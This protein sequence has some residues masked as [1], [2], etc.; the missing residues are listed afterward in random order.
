MF[1]RTVIVLL[2]FCSSGTPR[3]WLE[4]FRPCLAAYRSF[5]PEKPLRTAHAPQI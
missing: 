3:T 1:S 4:C 5:V 2:S